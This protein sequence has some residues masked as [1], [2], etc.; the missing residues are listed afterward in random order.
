MM[1]TN[2][3]RLALVDD[4]KIVIDGLT[5]V[6]KEQNT[7]E[8]VVTANS[9]SNMLQLLQHNKVDILLSDV[10]MDGMNGLQLAKAVRQ[11]F[12]EI[13]IIALSMN[14]AG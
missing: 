2:K 8:I 13:K 1:Q 3:I 6:L 5:A 10:M 12:P 7:V 4:H 9:G 14:G 11:Q